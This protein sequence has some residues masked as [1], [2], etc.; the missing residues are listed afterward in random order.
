LNRTS[1]LHCLRKKRNEAQ[2]EEGNNVPRKDGYTITD[3]ISLEDEQ[4][5]WP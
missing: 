2:K 5:E 3:E 4:V 1:T